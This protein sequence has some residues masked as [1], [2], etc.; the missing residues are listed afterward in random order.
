MEISEDVMLSS[1]RQGVI[2]RKRHVA[3]VVHY[4]L[5]MTCEEAAKVV[6]R[7]DPSAT[8]NARKRVRQSEDLR[9]AVNG[10]KR[11]WLAKRGKRPKN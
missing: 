4:E 5:G 8:K 2:S 11:A 7:T 10:L 9:H 1:A 3:Q 6:G